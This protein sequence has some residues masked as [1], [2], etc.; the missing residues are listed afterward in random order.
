MRA[1]GDLRRQLD[2]AIDR[3]GGQQ[4]QVGLGRV[5]SRSWVIM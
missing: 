4:E 1:V 3:P 5:A 2:A